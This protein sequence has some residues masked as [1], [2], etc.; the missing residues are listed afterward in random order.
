MPQHTRGTLLVVLRPPTLPASCTVVHLVGT[1]H[2]RPGSLSSGHASPACDSWFS[3][4]CCI[5]ISAQSRSTLRGYQSAVTSVC[6]CVCV[7]VLR[8]GSKESGFHSSTFA[9]FAWGQPTERTR[10][11]LYSSSLTVCAPSDCLAAIVPIVPS[12]GCS[13][14]SF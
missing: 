11:V 13:F 10:R 8:K 7:C 5:Y 2:D 3:G 4:S 1:S 14:N 6:V 9:A 12:C